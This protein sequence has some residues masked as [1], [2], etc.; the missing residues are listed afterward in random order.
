M[1]EDGLDLV[2]LIEKRGRIGIGREWRT[3]EQ[4][5]ETEN[6]TH[7]KGQVAVCCGVDAVGCTEVRVRIVDG[8]P[9]GS[10]AAIVQVGGE[11]S[12]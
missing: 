5:S 12:N 4:L 3:A 1:D 2:A 9:L 7:G 8:A 11:T 6:G 10:F